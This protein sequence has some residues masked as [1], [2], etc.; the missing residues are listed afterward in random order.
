[1]V[2]LFTIDMVRNGQDIDPAIRNLN[3]SHLYL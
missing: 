3:I 1:M 2:K